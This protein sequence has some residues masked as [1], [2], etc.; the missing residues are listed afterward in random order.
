MIVHYF[1]HL[2]LDDDAGLL[3]LDFI[4]M[5][6]DQD[7]FAYWGRKNLA[8]EFDIVIGFLYQLYLYLISEG[9]KECLTLFYKMVYWNNDFD[10]VR[11]ESKV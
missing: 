4:R 5:L 11:K 1:E 8:T 6:V 7:G 3:L 10:R 9:V 2:I